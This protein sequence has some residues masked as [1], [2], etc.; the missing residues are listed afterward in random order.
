MAGNDAEH[1]ARL[2]YVAHADALKASLTLHEN[3]SFAAGLVGVRGAPEKALGAFDLYRLAD[4]P[5][6]YLSTGQRRRAALARLLSSRAP[7]GYSRAGRRPRPAQ[8]GAPG[9]AIGEHR[10]GGGLAV[11]ATHG[12]VALASALVLDMPG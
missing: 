7:S 3:L 6:R 12:D 9:A 10:E 5:V 8:S 1:R 4:L 2:H 11:V